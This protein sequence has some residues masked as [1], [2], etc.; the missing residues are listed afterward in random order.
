MSGTLA[1]VL[2]LYAVAAGPVQVMVSTCSWGIWGIKTSAKLTYKGA[3]AT[4]R[5][6][7]AA[8]DFVWQE[9]EEPDDDDKSDI[10]FQEYSERLQTK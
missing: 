8:K 3:K 6:A 4:Y 5:G 1:G 7:C 9:V 10:D 2:I